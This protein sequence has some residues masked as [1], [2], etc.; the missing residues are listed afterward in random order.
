MKRL[1]FLPAI[2]TLA[3]CGADEPGRL[4]RVL[5]PVDVRVSTVVEGPSVA[6]IPATVVSERTADIATRT[7][8]TVLEVLVQVGSSV[9]AGTPLLLLDGSDITA[10]VASARAQAE[11]ARTTHRRLE[12]LVRDGAASQ[13]E[14]DQAQ[15]QL[16]AAEGMLAEALAQES[17]VRVTAP[18]DGIIT[19]RRVDA[20]D[21][22]LPGHPLLTLM[23]PG[24][25]K[26]TAEVPAH[27]AGS[28]TVGQGVQIRVDGTPELVEG[29]IT[30]VVSALGGSS[31]TF[32]V[33]AA[34]IGTP[35]GIL[36]GAHARI[37]LE[38][39]GEGSRWIPTDALVTRGQ[40]TGVFAVEDD[41]LRLRWIRTGQRRDG[42][43]EL[44]SGPPG[45]LVVVRSPGSELF[46]GHPVGRRT[47]EPWT[48]SPDRRMSAGPAGEVRP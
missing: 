17:Y 25:L 31:R 7:S 34:F 47:D 19:H 45:A 4:S 26:V 15:A 9:R 30:R 41:V 10:R 40:L 12:N 21:L 20:G 13:Q 11:L 23:A 42:A 43:I 1:L 44:L 28:L 33:E 3:A 18:F 38:G 22:A 5:E 27:R 36:P 29:R 16:Q 2:L 37:E 39:Q 46:D 8:G 35:G 32:R 48:G 14:L 6:S 24:A